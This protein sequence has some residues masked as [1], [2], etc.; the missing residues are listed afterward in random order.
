MNRHESLSTMLRLS[1]FLVAALLPFIG[2]ANMKDQI[3][4][5]PHLRSI[6]TTKQLYV[7]S[8]PFLI[9]GGELGN[10]NA[11][12]PNQ[13]D[14]IFT[15]LHNMNLNTVMLPVYWD[16]VEPEEGKFDFAL[17]QSAIETARKHDMK[18]VFLWFGTWKNSMSCYAP[19]WVKRDTKRFS[20]VRK[21]DGEAQEIV[22]P[23]SDSCAA[24]D[25]AAFAELMRWTKEFDESLH[26]VVMVQVENEIGMIPEP[27]DH[28]D[29]S[30]KQYRSSVPKEL[31]TKLTSGKLGPEVAAIWQG[32]GGVESGTWAEVFGTEPGGEEVFSAWQFATYTDC[33]A[34]AGKKVYDLPMLTNAALIRPGYKPG[35]YPSGGPLPHLIEVW[36][37]GAPNLDLLSPDIYFPN[38][39]E[40]IDRYMRSGNS[41]FIPEIAPSTRAAANALYAYAKHHAIGVGPF[42]IENQTGAKERD[43]TECF[44]ILKKIAPVVLD[45]Q[46]RGKILGLSPRLDFDWKV[47]DEPEKGTLGD[48]VFSAAFDKTPIT[49]PGSLSTLPTL[50]VG[51]W[52]TPEGAPAGS[53]MILQI[54]DEEFVVI[55]KGVKIT[56]APADGKGK[57]GIESVHE[58]NFAADG[59]WLGARWLNGDETHQGRHVALYDGSWKV[60][61]VKLYRYQ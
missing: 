33:V 34:A 28:S 48:F 61:R 53:V 12:D 50:G 42:S 6:G 19:G 51:R 54:D 13:L 8:K 10:S 37:T 46:A 7:N 18:L 15:K 24:K 17:V 26:T 30:E 56:F 21:K 1:T 55:G 52:E 20:R 59:K 4:A 49:N 35:Q 40:W 47:G 25:A 2:A 57:V 45:C 14:A 3:P 32:A 38:F 43:I 11:S 9:L 58:G 41:L 31:I 16:R 23:A 27:R 5:R 60:Q 44:G 29:E 22:T 39:S 36:Q